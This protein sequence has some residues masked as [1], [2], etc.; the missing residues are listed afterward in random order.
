MNPAIKRNVMFGSLIC[1]KIVNL[2]SEKYVLN[3]V[4]LW[5]KASCVKQLKCVKPSVLFLDNNLCRECKI[6]S[7]VSSCFARV[8]SISNISKEPDNHNCTCV[9]KCYSLRKEA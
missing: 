1:H 3:D 7:R 9:S 8:P 4:N 2:S 5:G 6:L